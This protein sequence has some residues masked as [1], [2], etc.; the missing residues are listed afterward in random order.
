MNPQYVFWDGITSHPLDESNW[1]D[2]I[3]TY[4]GEYISLNALWD[5]ARSAGFDP[6]II[7][8]CKPNETAKEISVEGKCHGAF[9]YACTRL[10][11]NEPPCI[12]GDVITR[13]NAILKERHVEQT[14]E[15]LCNVALLTQPFLTSGFIIIADACRIRELVTRQIVNVGEAWNSDIFVQ[16]T[17]DIRKSSGRN[18]QIVLTFSGHGRRVLGSAF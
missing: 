17:N 4:D 15:V 6:V 18:D 1:H 14:A 13:T 7:F 9:T 16:A 5:S 8:S 10:I 2:C 11:K 12:L 3:R